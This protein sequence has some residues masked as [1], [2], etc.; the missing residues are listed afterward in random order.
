MKSIL[1]EHLL[2]VILV[3][4]TKLNSSRE[5][6]SKRKNFFH[7]NQI[8]TTARSKPS[9]MQDPIGACSRSADPI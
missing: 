6:V 7:F 4:N 2:A 3:E 8:E 1:H 9:K 5:S